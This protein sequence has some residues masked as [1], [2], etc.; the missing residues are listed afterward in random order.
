MAVLEEEQLLSFRACWMIVAV[1]DGILSG[2]GASFAAPAP[3]SLPAPRGLLFLG[4][5]LPVRPP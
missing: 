4:G 5:F 3:F 2:F 1:L